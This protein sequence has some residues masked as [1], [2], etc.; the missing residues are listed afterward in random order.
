ME[1]VWVWVTFSTTLLVAWW[2]GLHSAF[3]VL[4][5]LQALDVITGVMVAG[6]YRRLR[7]RIG[8]AG[9]KRKT[10]AWL[11]LAAL[12][13]MQGEVS[14]IIEWAEMDGGYGV[15]QWSAGGLALMEFIS[16]AENV[17]KLGVPLPRWLRQ[18]L[19]DAA[20]KFGY[21]DETGDQTQDHRQSGKQENA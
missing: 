9:I 5:V 12:A 17:A 14:L 19:A 4:L 11:L 15:A 13:Y 2:A 16:I 10:A 8:A 21:G 6:K 7:S 3:R 20:E 18:T 1:R